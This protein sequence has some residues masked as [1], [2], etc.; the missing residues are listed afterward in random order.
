MVLGIVQLRM[1][2]GWKDGQL[3]QWSA[4]TPTQHPF[5]RHRT[6]I[7]SRLCSSGSPGTGAV[8]G[9]RRRRPRVPCKAGAAGAAT[10]GTYVQRI[11]EKL[12]VSSR[13][14]IIARRRPGRG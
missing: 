14:E 5:T 11:Y 8:A 4:A 1:V 13:R 10:V 9:I 2:N 7:L 12:H 6:R 3:R